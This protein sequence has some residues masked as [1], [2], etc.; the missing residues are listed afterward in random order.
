MRLPD[1]VELSTGVE[2]AVDCVATQELPR[3]KWNPRVHYR[4]HRSPQLFH[5]LSQTNPI[6]TILSH[7]SKIHLNIIH[8]PHVLV[9]V[10]K[11]N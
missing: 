9:F 2:A 11:R 8:L 1:C 6:H 5:I 10:V 3:I 4:F 7:L